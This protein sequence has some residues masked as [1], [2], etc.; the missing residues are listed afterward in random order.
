MR[1][2]VTGALEVERAAKHVGSALEAAPQ[3]FITAA[4]AEA[5]KGIDLAEV[6]IT[7]A[8]VVEIGPVPAGAFTI[9]EVS[10]VGVVFV[11]A[12]GD[13]CA[14]CWRVLPEVG[15]HG[16]DGLCERCGDAVGKLTASS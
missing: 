6:A 12:D 15:H 9:S 7:S 11:K 14:R 8:I 3:V 10:D 16:H 13:K 5:L 2:V 1:R 4:H